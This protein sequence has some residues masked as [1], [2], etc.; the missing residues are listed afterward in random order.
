MF[1]SNKADINNILSSLEH[2]EEYIKGDVNELEFATDFEHKKLKLIEDKI[3]SIGNHLKDQRTQD[4]KVYG[5]IMLVCEKLSDGFTDDE[6]IEV[7]SD[8]KINYIAKTINQTVIKI[9]DSLQK[10]THIL[11]EYENHNFLN[12]V[13]ETL[14]RGGELQNLL[15]GL[16]NLQK[17]ITQRTAQ[18]Y[19]TGL[20][21]EYESKMLMDESTSL[22]N[23]TQKQAVAIEETAA[24]VEQITSNISSNTQ[25]AIKMSSHSEDLRESANQSLVLSASTTQAMED[26]D[27]STKAVEDA[28]GAISQIAFQT[29]ILSL[30]AAVE[31][32]TAGEA[33]KGFAVVAQEVRNL[34]TRSAQSAQVIEN[35]ITKLKEQT[36]VGKVSS[37]KM[38]TEYDTLN[39]NITQTLE[40]VEDIVNAS[41]EQGL[42]IQQIND[43]IQDIDRSTQINAS[44][45][46]KVKHISV[47]SYNISEQLVDSNKD[48]LF[49][50]KED[51]QIR[52]NSDNNFDGEDKRFDF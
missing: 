24:A 16:N 47:Q 18:G 25:T 1:F 13:D 11:N 36:Q 6:V 14:F 2:F 27:T 41:K 42:G 7:S 38:Q 29:N 52:M 32:A 9:D 31:A 10:V 45:A 22:L 28:I 26:I 51:I 37:S 48:V 15:K 3:I 34:A 21:L 40:L 49:V 33:G 8:E 20:A 44:I 19:R 17:G 4:L 39:L 35:L 30:N 46:E 43:S 12:S 23:S 5:E 50:G